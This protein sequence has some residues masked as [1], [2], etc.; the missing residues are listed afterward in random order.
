MAAAIILVLFFH[1]ESEVGFPGLSFLSKYGHYGVDIFFFASGIGCWYSLSKNQEPASF[2][3]RRIKRIM[4]VFLTFIVIWS[5]F[6]MTVSQMP[7]LSVLGNA[8]GVEFLRKSTEWNFNWY[9]SGMWVSYLIAPLFYSTVKMLSKPKTVLVLLFLYV[10]T[11]P[12]IGNVHFLIILTRLPIFY[13][14]F[15]T[16]KAAENG[17]SVTPVQIA[18]MDIAAVF[19]IILT[20]VLYNSFPEHRSDWGL[21]WYPAIAVVPGICF[22]ISVIFDKISKT[23]LY[24]VFSVIGKYTFEIY[25]VHVFLFEFI[26]AKYPVATNYGTEFLAYAVSFVSA[27]VLNKLAYILTK[28]LSCISGKKDNN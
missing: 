2:F 12:F 21:G 22:T 7:V 10:L 28:A 16:A 15:L 6:Q 5:A 25:L 18:I 4:P 14:G 13:L 26:L 8:L 9:I 11:V 23:K 3:G 20:G 24:G 17:D 19:G 1:A 27:F